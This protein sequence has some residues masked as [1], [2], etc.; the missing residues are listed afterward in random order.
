MLERKDY[1]WCVVLLARQRS[2]TNAVR[3]LLN[4]HRKISALPEVFHPEPSPQ[5]HLETETNYFGFVDRHPHLRFREVLTSAEEQE[6]AFLEY[7]DYL[8]CLSNKQ[9]IVLDVKYTSAHHL[10]GPWRYISGEPALFALIRK[11]RL[12]VLNLRRR[13]YLRFYISLLKA[14]KSAQWTVAAGSGEEGFGDTILSRHGAEKTYEDP[15]ITVPVEQLTKI[16]RV[17]CDDD[18]MVE[19][20]LATTRRF[21]RVEYDEL[22]PDVSGRPAEAEMNRIASWLGVRRLPR[23]RPKYGK[24]A[25]RLLSETIE[26][27]GEVERALRGTEFE[28]CLEDER[29]HRVPAAI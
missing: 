13:N 1:S 8:R 28:Y 9:Y 6:R 27:Y 14:Q 10:D 20:S 15:A 26:N 7:L 23:E 5:A 17:S 2:G 11:H 12:R 19:Q 21:P 24:Q 18:L 16:L 22:F 4:R 29:M 25:V 3:D